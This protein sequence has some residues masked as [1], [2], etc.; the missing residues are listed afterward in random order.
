MSVKLVAL[1]AL[2]FTVALC[3]DTKYTPSLFILDH[4]SPEGNDYLL[5]WVDEAAEGHITQ[6]EVDGVITIIDFD[7]RCNSEPHIQFNREVQIGESIT[8]GLAGEVRYTTT[9]CYSDE[10]LEVKL[11]VFSWVSLT[12]PGGCLGKKR[13]LINTPIS[14]VSVDVAVIGGSL[15]ELPSQRVILD[16]VILREKNYLRQ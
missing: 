9:G 7:E 14:P 12:R 3:Y 8:T 11:P 10:D 2:L 6:N 5:F 15:V 13:S 1:F 4:C 16:S